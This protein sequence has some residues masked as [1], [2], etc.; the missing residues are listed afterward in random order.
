MPSAPPEG[1][2]EPLNDLRPGEEVTS[3]LA[4][5][6]DNETI[7]PRARVEATDG[8]LG[9]VRERGAG[10]QADHAY[11]GVETAEGMVY[12]PD[13]LIRETRGDT[14]VLSLPMADVR[15]QS[16]SQPRMGGAF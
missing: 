7:R 9:V 10:A 6:S 5:R 16:A 15:A 3:S 14:V 8:V 13:R 12:V 4:F 2:R 11:L 1:M